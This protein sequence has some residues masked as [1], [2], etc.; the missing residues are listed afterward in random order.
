MTYFMNPLRGRGLL[1]SLVLALSAFLLTL[2][3]IKL[4]YFKFSGNSNLSLLL[5]FSSSSSF[6]F[7]THNEELLYKL[8]DIFPIKMRGKK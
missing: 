3:V 1:D 4:H 7:F 2:E 5:F 6:S 8:L